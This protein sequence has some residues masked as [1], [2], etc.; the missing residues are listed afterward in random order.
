MTVT[1]LLPQDDEFFDDWED[2]I[3]DI[4]DLH[5]RHNNGNCPDECLFCEDQGDRE[6]E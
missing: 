4:E 3:S 1:L 5:E 6:E 2:F